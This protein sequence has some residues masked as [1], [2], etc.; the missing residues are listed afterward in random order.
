MA[1]SNRF[2]YIGPEGKLYESKPFDIS[3]EDDLKIVFNRMIQMMKCAAKSS[4][5]T[6]PTK[7]GVEQDQELADFKNEVFLRLYEPQGEDDNYDRDLTEMM[8][9]DE[10]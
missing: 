2:M 5:H 10:L 6:S 4:P 7:P 8:E 3:F 9:I 1:G